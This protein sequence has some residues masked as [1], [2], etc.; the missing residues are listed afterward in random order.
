MQLPR[1]FPGLGAAVLGI[2]LITSFTTLTH[3]ATRSWDGS[4]SGFWNVGANWTDGIA[5]ANGDALLFPDGPIRLTITNTVGAPVNFTSVRFT[6]PDYVLFGPPLSITNGLTNATFFIGGNTIRSAISVRT[7]QSW[8]VVSRS[9]LTLSSN[10]NFGNLSV[11]GFISGTLVLDGTLTGGFSSRFVKESGGRM[12][13]NGSGVVG[14][15]L[16]NDGTLQVDGAMGEGG[17]ITIENGASLIGTGV[18]SPFLSRGTISPGNTVP[19][20]LTVLDTANDVILSTANALYT[21]QLN[22]PTPGTE[23]DQLSVPDRLQVLGARLAV[24]VGTGFTPS[25]GQSFVII[26]NTSAIPVTGSFEGLT[27]G[28]TFSVSNTTFRITYVGGDGNDVVLRVVGASGITRIWDGGGNAARLWMDAPNWDN[29]VAADAGDSLVFPSGVPVAE[30]TNQNNFPSGTPFQRLA[31]GGTNWTLNG[32]PIRLLNGLEVTNRTT[33]LTPT[34][35]LAVVLETNQT[36]SVASNSLTMRSTL[37]LGTNTLIAQAANGQL[38]LVGLV[39]GTGRIV[40]RGTG[41]LDLAGTNTFTGGVRIENGL[42][43]ASGPHVNGAPWEMVSSGARLSIPGVIPGLNASAGV[44]RVPFLANPNG[45]SVAGNLTLASIVTLEYSDSIVPLSVTGTVNLASATLAGLPASLGALQFGATESILIRNDGNDPVIGTFAGLPEGALFP[46]PSPGLS[47]LITYVGGDGNDVALRS[48][49]PNP[50]LITRIW[51]GTGTNASWNTPGNWVA[52]IRPSI[53]DDLLFPIAAQQKQHHINTESAI[54][55]F[56]ANS[57]QFDGADYVI[58][59]LPPNGPFSF[60][61]GV[62]ALTKGIRALQSFGTNTISAIVGVSADQEWTVASSDAVLRFTGAATGLGTI[63]KTGAGLLEGVDALFTNGVRFVNG[64]GPARF[65]NTAFESVAVNAG[66]VDFVGGGATSLSA[67]GGVTRMSGMVAT[68]LSAT[69][70]DLRITAGTLSG[71]NGQ[72]PGATTNFNLGPGARCFV[73]FPASN[74]IAVLLLGAMNIDGAQLDVQAT[75]PVKAGEI[76]AVAAPF[77]GGA[78][79]PFPPIIPIPTNQPPPAVINGTFAGLPNG[80]VTNFSGR[81][82]R[83]HYALTNGPVVVPGVYL[84]ALPLQPQF[85]NVVRQ[86]SGLVLLQGTAEPAANL[87]LEG[88]QDFVQ[89]AVL[90]STT[91]SAAGQFQFTDTLAVGLAHRFYRVRQQ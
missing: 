18:A 88:S 54:T 57:L 86:V 47:N 56:L 90:G 83:I 73:E 11:T 43:I 45:N 53:G 76:L 17:H 31:I 42:V 46:T 27:E 32:N 77:P 34:L 41:D 68:R 8:A 51:D 1:C 15:I 28:A 3:A 75:Y 69:N 21:V 64:S 66:S 91:T 49:P 26:T 67:T 38:R 23:Y 79:I 33:G 14:Q 60:N 4:S 55:I 52:N 62:V 74:S 89:W 20:K 30:R 40:K 84:T 5:P 25:P 61:F 81:P 44:L 48:V 22:G 35:N 10:V 65:K 71:N 19:G 7:N 16:V 58:S 82:F 87:V 50:T 36:W 13:I 59:N 24:S 9:S 80:A 85:T 6:G 2:L 12:E 63:R 72:F 29:D 37:N 70:A 39:T 78:F